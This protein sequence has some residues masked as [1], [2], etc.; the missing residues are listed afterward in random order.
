MAI[1]CRRDGLAPEQQKALV[2]MRENASIVQTAKHFK[3]STGTVNNYV[4]RALA[5]KAK[6]K[7]KR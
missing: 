4:K 6:R 5:E 1:S 3:V 7:R 2:K